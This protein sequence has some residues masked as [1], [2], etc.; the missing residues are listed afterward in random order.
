LPRQLSKSV[1]Q[2]AAVTRPHH[3]RRQPL[4]TPAS[5][6]TAHDWIFQGD[7]HTRDEGD[8]AD[9]T[10]PG[11]ISRDQI[12]DIASI[13]KKL[14]SD[15]SG[16]LSLAELDKALRLL[17]YEN[18]EDTAE[19]VRLIDKDGSGQIEWEEFRSLMVTKVV[20]ESNE[21]EMDFTFDMLDLNGDGDISGDELKALLMHRGEKLS[22]AEADDLVD[23]L[24]GGTGVVTYESF[25]EGMGCLFRATPS[26]SLEKQHE[27]TPARRARLSRPNN[28]DMLVGAHSGMVSP[29]TELSPGLNGNS[30]SSRGY[31]ARERERATGVL[32][33]AHSHGSQAA[34][35]VFGAGM[36]G[37]IHL[38]ARDE[39][40]PAHSFNGSDADAGGPPGKGR[41]GP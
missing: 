4:K 28:A 25:R 31:S 9:S 8:I 29:I 33:D 12:A 41:R 26:T 13:W 30:S 19:L 39:G 3:R 15:G 18:D 16:S 35:P 14:D 40:S 22:A 6:A 21:V 10:P 5:W 38:P 2:F 20:E 23:L 32:A 37:S 11:L 7:A 17:G 24:S 34:T 36:L 1:K 27:E